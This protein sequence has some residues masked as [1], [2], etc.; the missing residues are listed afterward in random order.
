MLVTFLETRRISEDGFTV[1][2]CEQGKT[3]DLADNAARHAIS[4]GWAVCAEEPEDMQTVTNK[5]IASLRCNKRGAYLWNP[6][7]LAE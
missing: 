7:V 3:Y 1:R 4:Q 5:I 2:R 6:E